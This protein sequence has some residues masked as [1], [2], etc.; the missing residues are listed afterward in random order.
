MRS[1][2]AI[3]RFVRSGIRNPRH[4]ISS[5]QTTNLGTFRLNS[6]PLSEA[7]RLLGYRGLR[8]GYRGFPYYYWAPAYDTPLFVGIGFLMPVLV[9]L[10]YTAGLSKCFPR[11]RLCA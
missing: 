5:I 4:V 9:A 10:S 11:I 1:N 6:A 8:S 3:D 7:V 2:L